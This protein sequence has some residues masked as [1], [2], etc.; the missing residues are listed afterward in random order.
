[1]RVVVVIVSSLNLLSD[2]YWLAGRCSFK[3][4]LVQLNINN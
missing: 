2:Y 4:K 1:M 3:G